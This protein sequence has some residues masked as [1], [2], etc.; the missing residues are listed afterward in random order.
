MPSYYGMFSWF[1]N[2]NK[3]STPSLF[4]MKF[5]KAKKQAATGAAGTTGERM[6]F[7]PQRRGGPPLLSAAGLASES[8]TDRIPYGRRLPAA[9]CGEL[10]NEGEVP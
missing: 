7:E 5:P 10:K 8:E 6:V 4:E 2:Q 1:D 3:F 9:C